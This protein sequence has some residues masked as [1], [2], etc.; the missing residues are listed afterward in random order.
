MRLQKIPS[1]RLLF[2][3]PLLLLAAGCSTKQVGSKDGKI[4]FNEKTVALMIMPTYMEAE[5]LRLSLLKGRPLPPSAEIISI[6]QL[7]G[8]S[9]ALSTAAAGLRECGVSRAIPP[10]ET[11]IGNAYIVLQKG[12]AAG[13]TCQGIEGSDSKT[14]LQKIDEKGGEILLGIL[15]VGIVLFLIA[16]PFLLL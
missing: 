10:S 3:I 15:S 16:L 5:T 2:Y 6:P 11:N 1:L 12:N 14:L 8:I 9:T 13:T 4:V 7:Q